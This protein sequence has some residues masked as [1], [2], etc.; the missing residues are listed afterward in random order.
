[1]RRG[2][3]TLPALPGGTLY[4]T[5]ATAKK[6]LLHSTDSCREDEKG[7]EHPPCTIRSTHRLLLL[8]CIIILLR[9]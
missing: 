9:I 4:C 5:V 6:N 2:G 3:N 8:I 1:M 7:G